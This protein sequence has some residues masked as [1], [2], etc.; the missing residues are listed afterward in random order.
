MLLGSFGDIIKNYVELSIM[1]IPQNKQ[2]LIVHIYGK[3]KQSLSIVTI[4]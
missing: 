2:K 3:E 4:V 1:S